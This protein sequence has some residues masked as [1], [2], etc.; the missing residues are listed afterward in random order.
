M[1]KLVTASGLEYV[2]VRPPILK[3]DA[4]KGSVTLLGGNSTGHA[5]T[6]GDLAKFLVEQLEPDTYLG[7]AVTVVNS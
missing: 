4:P 6:R 7:R 5:V 1:E 2:I 3:D